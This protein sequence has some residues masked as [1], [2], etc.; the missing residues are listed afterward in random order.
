MVFTDLRVKPEDDT[1]KMGMKA[2]KEKGPE[3][4]KSK[5]T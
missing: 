4:D 1:K 2:H 3:E 5:K